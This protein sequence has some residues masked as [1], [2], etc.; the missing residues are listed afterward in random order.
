MSDVWWSPWLRIVD[1]IS[2]TGLRRSQLQPDLLLGLRRMHRSVR[3]I[4]A[5]YTVL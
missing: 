3:T 5:L 4:N 2:R 1:L